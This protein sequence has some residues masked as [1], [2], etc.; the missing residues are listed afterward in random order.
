MRIWL[1]L[2]ANS[3]LPP[4]FS[5]ANELLRLPPIPLQPPVQIIDRNQ[6]AS[7][8]GILSSFTSY[9]SSYAADD[10]PEP[11]E[12][13][14]ESTLCT[15]DCLSQCPMDA[16]FGE[17]LK[18]PVEGRQVLLQTLLHLLP[19]QSSPLVISVKPEQP[20]P[21]AIR[22]NGHRLRPNSSSYDPSMVFILEI[23]TL[24]ATRDSQ[25]IALMG[26]AVVDALQSVVRDSAN[27]HLLALSRS[28]YYLLFLLEATQSHSIVRAPVVLHMIS[29][30]EQ[31]VLETAERE[32]VQGLSLCVRESAP[33][34]NEI[35]NTPDFW[36]ILRSLH[37]R[38]SVDG[39]VF[40]LV[41]NVVDQKPAA[42]TADNYEAAMSL[43]NGFASAG[44]VGAAAEQKLDRKALDLH[45]REKVKQ[46]KNEKVAKL[47]FE[48]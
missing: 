40:E 39:Q 2:F 28:I 42:I 17:V 26:E 16:L 13:E 5:Q 4:S 43:L 27:T 31:N 24:I 15:V 1:N 3:L 18:M 29:K 9:L 35:T 8:T 34:R 37:M 25:S 12:E 32:I 7:E 38:P 19:E 22:T 36:L 48:K 47:P 23:A 46:T 45:Q 6:R 14:L 33:L 30:Y 20:R 41:R 21:S 10:P 11:S 44:S